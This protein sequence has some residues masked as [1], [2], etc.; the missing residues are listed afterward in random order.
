MRPA[1]DQAGRLIPPK[2]TD[3][4]LR[5]IQ[6]LRH[7]VTKIEAQLRDKERALDVEWRR[8]ATEKRQLFI[9]EAC[10]LDAWLAGYAAGGVQGDELLREAY[11][12]LQDI[13][14]A[15][16]NLGDL[17][18]SFDDTLDMLDRHFEQ[19]RAQ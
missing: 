14:I 10:W 7:E 16:V 1:L 11:D 12:M 6:Q 2:T 4:A 5:R 13:D 15:D 9:D 19:R 8:R 3:G 17:E 18:E